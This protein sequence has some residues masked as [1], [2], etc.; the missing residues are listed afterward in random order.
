VP[1]DR[2]SPN[3]DVLS[4]RIKAFSG[5]ARDYKAFDIIITTVNA[6]MQRVPPQ[7][8]FLN[9]CRVIEKNKPF[10][11]DEFTAFLFKN[12]FKRVAEVLDKGEYAVR[13]GILDVFSSVYNYPVRIDL[14][15]DKIESMRAFDTISQKSI[16]DVE[17]FSIMPVSEFILTSESI[18]CFRTKYRELFGNISRNDQLYEAVSQGIYFDG[19]ENWLPLF[20]DKMQIISDYI[21][22]AQI[23]V[24]A[25]ANFAAKS[26]AE[27]IFDYFNE[28]VRAK[29]EALDDFI[30]NPIPPQM[31]YLNDK[32]FSDFLEQNNSIFLHKTHIKDAVDS[33]SYPI[34]T[35]AASRLDENKNVYQ[36][37]VD[38]INLKK[39]KKIIIA[40][41]S[42]VS[43]N[44]IKNLLV[45]Y[46]ADNPNALCLPI[47]NGFEDDE[48]CIISE[49]EI[50]G[51]KLINNPKRHKK[52]KDF[53][54]DV[55]E[56]EVGDIVVHSDHGI[57]RYLG[58]FV[59]NID[60]APHDCL[61][62]EYNDGDKLFVPVENLEMISRYGDEN[63]AIILDAL[64]SAAWQS[65]KAKVKAKIFE[66]AEELI[67]IAALRELKKGELFQH[68][69]GVYEEFAAKFP[70]VETEDQNRAIAD[71][72]KDL[73]NDKPMDRLICG[74]VGFGKTEV[75]MRAAFLA[76]ASGFKCS[77]SSDYH[78]SF[79][80]F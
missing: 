36:D 60:N 11:L 12:G 64:G 55:S 10:D 73:E 6:F 35:F 45:Q 79:A 15:G 42:D 34:K 26:R 75:A 18:T 52:A 23:I 69:P 61:K 21:P 1:Y 50:V 80:A 20:F 25:D 48:I 77:F 14:F 13:G 5:L 59:L 28:R 37:V 44:R 54:K 38:F 9:S 33:E 72:I 78:F 63:S 47:M 70:Y 30:Y 43:L 46:G 49:Q 4:Q 2:I 56:I 66:M 53:I 67:K 74:D 40:A 19:L 17:K 16:Y 39:N 51:E 22:N 58:L 57:G 41:V 71:V 29:K 24:D 8:F 7:K 62:I 76:V 3:K 32:E 27:I 65:R 68:T 31:F